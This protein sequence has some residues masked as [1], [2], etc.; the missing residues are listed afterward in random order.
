MGARQVVGRARLAAGLPFP[1]RRAADGTT[2]HRTTATDLLVTLAIAEHIAADMPFVASAAVCAV[3]L[4]VPAL[5]AAEV[6]A[7]RAVTLR[8]P[9]LAV[10]VVARL[11]A[12]QSRAVRLPPARGEGTGRTLIDAVVDG[13]A[14][15]GPAGCAGRAGAT[16]RRISR[17]G[18]QH[19]VQAAHRHSRTDNRDALQKRPPSLPAR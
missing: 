12:A 2:P 3:R 10:D 8:T 4:A 15:R 1:R 13:A 19:V 14:Q 17:A 16:H 5:P 9:C 18:P 7:G 6:R 11:A